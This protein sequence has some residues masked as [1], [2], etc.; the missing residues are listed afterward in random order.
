MSDEFQ[1]VKGLDMETVAPD[2]SLNLQEISSTA[3]NGDDMP[4]GSESPNTL[5]MSRS[6]AKLI[7]AKVKDTE[8]TVKRTTVER[9]LATRSMAE[10]VVFKC[11]A[12]ALPNAVASKTP[13]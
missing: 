1:D 3:L 11:V 4:T 12:E 9:Q 2:L 7:E 8:I 10:L 6:R 5:V 13:R